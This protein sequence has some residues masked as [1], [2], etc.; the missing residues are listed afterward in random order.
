[1]SQYEIIEKYTPILSK[2]SYLIVGLPDAGL[3][4]VIATE[5]L[6]ERLKLKEFAE[7][8]APTILPPISHVQDGIAKS[9]IRLY[10]NH[11]M[12]VFHSWIAIP[13]S[14]INV[15]SR[16]IVDVAKKYGISNIISITGL[17]I[18]DRLNAEKLN[19]YWI[20]NDY[21]TAQDLQKLGLMEKFGDGYIAGPYA[22][23]LI[24]SHKNNL[25][26]F[27]IVVESFLDLPD[28]EAS[29]IALTI[30][31]KYIGFSISVDE[32]LKE[33]EDIRDK[34]KGLME[35]T[36]QELPTYASNRPMTYA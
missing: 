11:N 26:N 18:Q 20:A 14:A 3:V 36:K 1:M 33:A 10:H 35:Q 9:P 15:I 2:P 12:I 24:E 17:P 6:I 13:S 27:V 8:Y 19:A 5:Y 30:L 28:P 31:S 4:G 32:L 16:I 21:N 34:I 23:L 25:S 7:I 29:A 22:P